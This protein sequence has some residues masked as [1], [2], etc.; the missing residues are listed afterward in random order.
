MEQAVVAQQPADASR[1]LAEHTRAVDVGT[2]PAPVV[3]QA[4]VVLADTLAIMLAASREGSVNTALAAFPLTESGPCTVVGH[5]RGAAAP[6]AALIN[7][8][9]GHD[10]ELDDSHSPSRTHAASVLVAAVLA[11]AE[12]AGGSNGPDLLAGLVAGYDIEVR[13]S[14]AMGVQRQFDR[15]FHPTCVCGT[16]GAAVAAGR[17]LGLD[18]E[19]L[20]CATS[21]A[22]SQSSGMQAWQEDPTHNQKSFHTGIAARNGVVAAML[23]L[24]GYRGALDVFTGKYEMLTPF[25]GENPD[26]SKLFDGLGERFDIC[27]T[28][29]K[30]YACGGQTHSSID[31][32]LTVMREHGL[33]PQDIE[34]VDVQLAH[35]AVP[36]IDNN[37]LWTA[38][39]QYI[40]AVAA[41]EGNVTREMF[42]DEWTSDAELTAFMQR[43]SVRGSDDLDQYFPEKKG[44]IVTVTT[45]AGETHSQRYPAPH[46]NP[47]EPLTDDE[48]R[49]K[50]DNLARAVLD[51]R[52]S[53]ELWSL[54]MDFENQTD[55]KELFGFIGGGHGG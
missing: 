24:H 34:T 35:G 43:V 31:A 13:L 17:V 41:R 54:L 3:R 22:A 21:L 44:A 38:N 14:K 33:T 23:A 4:K 9:G 48:L 7:G 8:I 29:I 47:G 20:Q 55:T 49:G 46:G 25:S 39:I 5:G 52:R 15:G 50:F 42:A 12:V 2:L 19:Q 10:I 51:E 53:D 28:S 11:A 45:R 32:L 27:D 30:L 36:I 6:Q 37:P 18:V 1:H 26:I 16:I 40:L